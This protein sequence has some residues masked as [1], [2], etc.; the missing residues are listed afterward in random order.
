MDELIKE[1]DI[2]IEELIFKFIKNIAKEFKIDSKELHKLADSIPLSFNE[3]DEIWKKIPDSNYEI[4]NMGRIK[5]VVSGKFMAFSMGR[6]YLRTG[7]SINGK[8]KSYRIHVLVAEYFIGKRPNKNVI[9]HKDGNRLNNKSSNL[10]YITQSENILHSF[11]VLGN[12]P[13]VI[14]SVYQMDLK[15][16]IIKKFESAAEAG[17]ILGIC[18]THI[19]CVCN[20]NRKSSGGFRWKF[21]EEKETESKINLENFHEIKGFNCYMVNKKGQ[22]YSKNTKRLL[23]IQKD[24]CGYF[25]ICI[26]KNNKGYNNFVHRLVAQTF[27]PNPENKKFVNHINHNRDDNNLENLEWV[28]IEENMKHSYESKDT[29]RKNT[30]GIIK[31]KKVDGILEEVAKFKSIREAYKEAKI[32]VTSFH[33]FMKKDNH[34]TYSWKID[35]TKIAIKS[36]TFTRPII[37]LLKGKE[38]NRFDSAKEAARIIGIDSGGIYAVCK[39]KQKSAGGFQWKYQ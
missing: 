10:E 4:S 22:I 30:V 35:L 24:K 8:S 9:N 25:Y 6:G 29:K 7:L 5:N 13:S 28:T 21:V 26:R 14:R 37:Q 36:K 23:K 34:P 2:L 16:K 3:P 17:R 39:E 15:G 31:Y 18:C 1:I 32:G 38:I 33:T 27:I 11:N 20:G 19:G 12:K